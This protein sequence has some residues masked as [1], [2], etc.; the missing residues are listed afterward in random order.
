MSHPATRH[1]WTGTAKI[2]IPAA[3]GYFWLGNL[4]KVELKNHGQALLNAATRG[5]IHGETLIVIASLVQDQ[6]LKIYGSGTNGDLTVTC[7]NIGDA[8]TKAAEHA[9]GLATD[10]LRNAIPKYKDIKALAMNQQW[11]AS[12][13]TDVTRKNRWET[14]QRA[15][16]A[17]VKNTDGVSVGVQAYLT[18]W[19]YRIPAP[20]MNETLN[21]INNEIL[22]RESNEDSDIDMEAFDVSRNRRRARESEDKS[23]SDLTDDQKKRLDCRL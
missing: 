19:D 18:R 7:Q 20:D 22:A 12:L 11:F 10:A 13:E 14:R 5:E 9:Q 15:I 6:R 21:L 4:P 16:N 2:P 17:K 8:I 1:P 23:G 3:Q